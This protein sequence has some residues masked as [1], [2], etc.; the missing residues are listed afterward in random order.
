MRFELNAS[1]DWRLTSMEDFLCWL[2][3]RAFGDQGKGSCFWQL[4]WVPLA[5]YFLQVNNTICHPG[6]QSHPQGTKSSSYWGSGKEKRREEVWGGEEL[7]DP[8][9]DEGFLVTQ[10]WGQDWWGR[11]FLLF[12]RETC[13][14]HSL[15]ILSV[16][17]L[18]QRGKV[19]G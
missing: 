15:S 18:Y 4:S 9:I 17:W 12:L 11:S 2:V 19:T 14:L 1:P 3:I 8:F 5:P 7:E 13:L 16:S 6:I 10:L